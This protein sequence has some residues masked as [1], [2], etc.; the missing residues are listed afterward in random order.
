MANF[1]Y[2]RKS[3]LLAEKLNILIRL[4]HCALP[5][6]IMRDSN[7]CSIRWLNFLLPKQSYRWGF[8][9]LWQ[10]KKKIPISFSED[11]LF[12]AH[13]SLFTGLA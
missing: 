6:N 12:D 8:G 11:C 3:G 2:K 9:L 10:H 4:S 5:L 13:G 7:L 1:P